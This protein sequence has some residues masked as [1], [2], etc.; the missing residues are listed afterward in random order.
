MPSLSLV[1]MMPPVCSQPGREL[2]ALQQQWRETVILMSLIHSDRLST[3]SGMHAVFAKVIC[4]WQIVWPIQDGREPM[5]LL[6]RIRHW[7][8][9]RLI[10]W[11]LPFKMAQM[12]QV[13][14]EQPWQSS[15]FR[16]AEQERM[17]LIRIML[18]DS[19]MSMQ[20]RV[21]W[22]NTISRDFTRQ[23][24]TMQ[25]LSC[26]ITQSLL[27]KKVPCKKIQKGRTLILLHMDLLTTNILLIPFCVDRWASRAISIPIPVSCT[28]CAGA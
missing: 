3:A 7:S 17:A 22:R 10:I 27:R 4:I 16:V 20:Q 28:I 9:K 26:H 18:Q 14:M 13:S 19:G 2:L 6:A 21:V 5:E 11:S 24:V 23:S 25:R 12:G 8:K 1:W 15:I